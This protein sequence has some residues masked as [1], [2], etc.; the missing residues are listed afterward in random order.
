ML[1]VVENTIE[2]EVKVQK[3]LAEINEIENSTLVGFFAQ[4]IKVDKRKNPDLYKKINN[5]AGQLQI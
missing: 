3:T 5:T 1:D 4:L 2:M